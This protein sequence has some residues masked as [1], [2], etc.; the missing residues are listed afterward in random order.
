M[1]GH[2][3]LL[4]IIILLAILYLSSYYLYIDNNISLRVHKLIWN[5][6]LILSA[7][8]VGCIGILMIIFLNLNML[9]IDGNIIYLHVEA[10]ILTATTGIFHIHMYWGKF[11][12][13]F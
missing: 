13:Y 1:M 10:G 8:V 11:K 3:Y 12:D 4:P 7:L 6:V 2:Y 9:P 5:I